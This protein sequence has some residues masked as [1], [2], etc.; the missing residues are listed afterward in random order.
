MWL[1]GSNYVLFFIICENHWMATGYTASDSYTQLRSSQMMWAAVVCFL[2][3]N[4]WLKCK[5]QKSAL[6]HSCPPLSALILCAFVRIDLEWKCT[7]DSGA[8]LICCQ[9][10]YYHMNDSAIWLVLHYFVLG[11][12][13][14]RPPNVTR[15]YSPVQIKVGME[16]GTGYEAKYI[17]ASLWFALYFFC[18]PYPCAGE[19]SVSIWMLFCRQTLALL[20]QLLM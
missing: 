17:L 9:R 15:P 16:I 1:T 2:N 8:K 20:S 14:V 5:S 6:N 13:N 11:E 10:C 7:I 12:V 18:S 19:V 3:E 4:T